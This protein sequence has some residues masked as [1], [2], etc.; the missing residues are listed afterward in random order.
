M[1]K[2]KYLLLILP[3]LFISNVKAA[4]FGSYNF[5]GYKIDDEWFISSNSSITGYISF[6]NSV[7]NL[8]TT[9]GNFAFADVC[10]TGNEPILWVTENLLGQL[11][12][13]TKCL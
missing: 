1:K 2:L 4:T 12:P 7:E 3:F 11:A 10:T 5:V 13:S 6:N 9:T 8:S